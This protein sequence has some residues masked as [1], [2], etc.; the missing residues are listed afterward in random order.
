MSHGSWALLSQNLQPT[1][2][3]VIIKYMAVYGKYHNTSANMTH[4]EFEK[5][6]VFFNDILSL[7]ILAAIQ[8]LKFALLFKFLSFH[9]FWLFKKNQKVILQL[10]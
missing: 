1:R 10:T 8:F 3:G 2:K 7:K 9:Y 6:G 5:G 4:L